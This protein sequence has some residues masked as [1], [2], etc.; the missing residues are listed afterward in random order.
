VPLADLTAPARRLAFVGLAKN[1]GKTVA[2]TALLSELAARGERV[3]VTSVGRDGEARDVLDA[4]I[5]KP[6]VRL[7]AGSLVA[8]TEPL[9]RASG[10][11]HARLART[12]LRTPLGRVTIARLEQGGAV[13]V[14]GPPQARDVRA[15]GEAML[16]LGAERVLVDGA[17]DRRAAASPA[18]ADGVVLCTG[19]ALHRDPVEVARRTRAAAELLA[20]PLVREPHVRAAAP[21]SLVG[22]D[23]AA[24]PFDPRIALDGDEADVA[25]LLRRAPG[26]RWIVLRGALC[27]PFAE[28]LARAAGGRELT[29]VVADG[30]RVFLS[31]RDPAW[32][33]AHGVRI[34]ALGAIALRAITVNPVAP[35]SHRFAP[36]VLPRLVGEAVPGVP[37]LDV[38][39]AVSPAGRGAG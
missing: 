36:D 28:R 24:V 6:R 18:V 17:L 3:G 7:G 20:L 30:T 35:G 11:A 10:L 8:T 32:Y 9:L 22:E 16:A 13:E 38:L 27:E 4:R 2:M 29:L 33:R 31:R 1:T 23:G 19:A 15:V 34:A 5:A 39:G 25:A 37:V 26:A 12:A 21:S 14:A